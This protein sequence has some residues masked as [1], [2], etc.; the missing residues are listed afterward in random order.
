[1]RIAPV[2]DIVHAGVAACGWQCGF[3]GAAS[4][5]VTDLPEMLPQLE[6]RLVQE[7]TAGLSCVAVAAYSWGDT[8]LPACAGAEIV[9]ASDV[10]YDATAH[11][12]FLDTLRQFGPRCKVFVAFEARAAKVLQR[13][14][15]ESVRV[16]AAVRSFGGGVGRGQPV[17]VVLC[18][19]VRQEMGF[20]DTARRAGFRVTL[21]HKA[22]SGKAVFLVVRA[23]GR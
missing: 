20:F 10:L 18:E 7:Q 11:A 15:T 23:T 9:L 2:F 6:A 8:L 19:C 1:M 16:P 14:A 3:L 4:V 21:V 5:V 13:R 12:A 22:G 17:C